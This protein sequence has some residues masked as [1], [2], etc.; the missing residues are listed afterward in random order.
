M[1]KRWFIAIMLGVAAALY[2]AR[3]DDSTTSSSGT[4][5]T[6]PTVTKPDDDVTTDNESAATKAMTDAE[7]AAK[8]AT[9]FGVPQQTILDMRQ[10]D[11]MGWG[12]IVISLQIAEHI[13]TTSTTTPPTAITA[14]LQQVLAL[15]SQGEGWGQIARA[16]GT[17]V[18]AI[19]HEKF[20]NP[21][22]VTLPT[23]A[24]ERPV[25]PEKPLK[26]DK[27]IRPDK[28]I[29]PEKPEKPEHGH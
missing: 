9:K 23:V 21:S 18:G 13:V 10:K 12:E 27:P 3:G 24:V 17:T 26:P 15:R 20:S 16:F 25:K 14:A 4:G 5:G 28:P 6:Q 22:G 29:K 2:N 1:N 19:K 8:L 11:H 7:R